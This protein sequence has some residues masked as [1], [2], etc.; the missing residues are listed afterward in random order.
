MFDVI[1]ALTQLRACFGDSATI[2]TRFSQQE[3][4]FEMYAD[5]G[6][7]RRMAYSFA[8]SLMEIELEKPKAEQVCERRFQE[9]LRGLLK[10][11]NES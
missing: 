4:I 7:G 3:L 10:L 1:K 11:Y 8:V 5:T 6:D 9:C 2:S